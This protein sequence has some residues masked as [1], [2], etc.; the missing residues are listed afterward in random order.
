MTMLTA[1][2]SLLTGIRVRGDTAM[3]GE[4]T[5]RGRVLPV[6]GIK[7]KVLAAHRA[8]IKRVILPERVRK[9]LDRRPEQAKKDIEFIFVTPDGRGP[10]DR[11]RGTDPFKARA[12][13]PDGGSTPDL[14][15]PEVVPPAAPQSAPEPDRRPCAA[16][17]ASPGVRGAE[18]EPRPWPTDGAFPDVLTPRAGVKAL[19]PGK[20]R[21][22]CRKRSDR[23][24]AEWPL[25]GAVRDRHAPLRCH[26]GTV[27]NVPRCPGVGARRRSVSRM[28]LEGRHLGRYRLLEPLGSG[29][30]SVVYRGLDTALQREVAVKVLHPHLARQQ[31]ARARLAREARAVARLQHPNILE[32][33]DFA[34]PS[35]EDAFLVTELVRGETLKSFAE[36]ERLF[37]PELA[38][39]VIQQLARALGHAHEAGVIHRDLKPENVMVRDDGVLKLMDFGI[40]RVL[41]PAERMT[42][43]GALVG[44]PAYMAPEVIDGEPATAESDVFSLGTLLYWL[45]TGTLPFAAPSTPATLKRILAGTYEDPRGVCPAISDALVAILDTCLAHDP[46]DRYASAKELEQALSET[47]DDLGLSDGEGILAAFFADPAATSTALVQRLVAT[48]LSKGAEEAA[49]GR[50]P[51]ALARVDQAL[52]LEPDGLRPGRCSTGSRPASAGDGPAAG[53]PP[54]PEGR[55]PSPPCSPGQRRWSGARHVPPR[56]RSR[57]SAR[58]PPLH[59][60]WPRQGP[61]PRDPRTRSP[62]RQRWSPP[63][64]RAPGSPP[65]AP[66]FPARQLPGPRPA[67][68]RPRPRPAPSAAFPGRRRFATRSWFAPT[69]GSPSTAGRAPRRSASTPSRWLRGVTSCAWA[70]SGAKIRWCPSRSSPA[71]P[72]PWRSPHGE[73]RRAALRLRAPLGRGPRRRRESRRSR[74]PLPPLRDRVAARADPLRPPGWSSR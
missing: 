9:D 13:T 60:W 4:I 38:A 20:P 68:L 21:V 8:G 62:G 31:D 67:Q 47:L 43:T 29:G 70:A 5:L 46:V 23:T 28:S 44:S 40:A 14:P 51:R 45:W 41:D 59:R 73:A 2:A 11:P 36:R 69:A 10:R 50:L 52:A 12:G 74:V 64:S 3:T 22:R 19:N 39:L 57:R 66:C 25:P 55:S 53:R 63:A 65:P 54:S 34:D 16:S 49:A 48:L 72:R 56:P 1:L 18:V 32:V 71:S 33:F 7:E 37:P 27:R 35:S 26:P 58:C 17:R 42:V 15:K 61:R 6:G 24:G 30:M